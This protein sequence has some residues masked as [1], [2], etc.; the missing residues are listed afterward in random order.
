M[1]GK[2]KC[3]RAEPN[4]M[5]EQPNPPRPLA[6][7]RVDPPLE[8][9][10]S[11]KD[12]EQTPTLPFPRLWLPRRSASDARGPRLPKGFALIVFEL[13]YRFLLAKLY[14]KS[15]NISKNQSRNTVPCRPVFSIRF[16]HQQRSKSDG[17]VPRKH[18][19]R[20]CSHGKY[21]SGNMLTTLKQYR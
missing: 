15:P 3:M 5:M 4:C 13:V 8:V 12:I 20:F 10:K 2:P 19:F 18:G 1:K 17:A 16:Y 11:I 9:F 21:C 6:S 7:R 14:P